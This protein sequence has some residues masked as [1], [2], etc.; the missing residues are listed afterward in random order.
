MAAP[1]RD[2]GGLVIG[3]IGVSAPATRTSRARDSVL[4]Q[5]VRDAAEHINKLLCE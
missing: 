2:Q 5:H 3:A 1:I 4:G